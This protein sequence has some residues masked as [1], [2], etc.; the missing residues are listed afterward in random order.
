VQLLW[1]AIDVRCMLFTG[2]SGAQGYFSIYALGVAIGSKL[3]TWSTRCVCHL[4]PHWLTLRG[5]GA[6]A[7]WRCW[8]CVCA[9]TLRRV[10]VRTRAASSST[11]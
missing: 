3:Q 9:S 5:V 6:G 4:R 8:R 11:Q 7:L 1:Y 2:V 10:R